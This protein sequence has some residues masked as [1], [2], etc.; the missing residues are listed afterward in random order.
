VT[1]IVWST[2]KIILNQWLPALGAR[3]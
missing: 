3:F 2:G 1:P